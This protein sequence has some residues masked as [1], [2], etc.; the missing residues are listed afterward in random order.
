MKTSNIVKLVFESKTK[1]QNN[2]SFWEMLRNK[3]NLNKSIKKYFDRNDVN[4]KNE[5]ELNTS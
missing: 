2:D 1:R 5:S 4:N 3:S